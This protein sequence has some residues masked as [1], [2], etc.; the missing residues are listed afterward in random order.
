MHGVARGEVVLDALVDQVDQVA[1]LTD[2][3]GDEQI[4]LERNEDKII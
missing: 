1:V 4:A 3:H 2:Q